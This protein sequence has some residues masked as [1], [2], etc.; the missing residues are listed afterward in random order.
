[1]SAKATTPNKPTYKILAVD[2]DGLAFHMAIASEVSINWHGD[3]WTLHSNANEAIESID[4]AIENLRQTLDADKV[5]VALSD[6]ANYRKE[7]NPT[8]KA[9]RKKDRKPVCYAGVIEHFKKA[10]NAI[11]MPRLEADD[12]LS[13]V[14]TS[15]PLGDCVIA[16]VDK[17]F[18]SVPCHFYNT[19]RADLRFIT[20]G[21]AD[22]AHLIQTLT[23]D[24]SDGYPGC[25][26]CGPV[27]ALKLLGDPHKGFKSKEAWPLVLE[28][29]KKAG[30]G[31]QQ[32]LL[33]ARMA[34]LL[35]K[36]DYDTQTNKV[37]LWGHELLKP[38]N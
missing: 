4:R 2:G 34:Y 20:A 11:T 36:G 10:Y 17:D 5:L 6:S 30:L 22:H 16:S 12:V 26:G 24:T 18:N 28:A 19:G 37:K 7:L 38:S 29:F 13:I 3:L 9:H 32:A 23:G 35:R 8:Y 15:L 21:E 25:P 33:Q 31:E 14:A 1:M 27:K